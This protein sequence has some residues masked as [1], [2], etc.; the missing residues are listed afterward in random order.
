MGSLRA[1]GDLQ[2]AQKTM[3]MSIHLT[4]LSNEEIIST[5]GAIILLLLQT[6]SVCYSALKK[7][8]IKFEIKV[9]M[10]SY[11]RYHQINK[12][13]RIYGKV[14]EQNKIFEFARI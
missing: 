3:S 14:T 7:N 2:N 9:E 8:Q 4:W 6:L 12:E 11:C 5:Y 1:R 10:S 13:K